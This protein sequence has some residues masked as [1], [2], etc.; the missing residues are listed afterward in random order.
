MEA[1]SLRIATLRMKNFQ[2]FGPKPT[3]IDLTGVTFVLGPNGAGKT[4]VLE[5]LARLFSPIAAQ[6]S[7][8]LTDFH[9]PLNIA[10]ATA[11]AVAE[12]LWIEVEIEFPETGKDGQHPSVPANFAHMRL[13]TE[14]GVPR[15]RVRLTAGTNAFGEVEERIEYV[16]EVDDNEEPIDV[17]TMGRYDR[18]HIEVHYLPARRDPGDHISYATSSLIGRTLRAADWASEAE[19]LTDLS[20]QISNVLGAN[21][22][23]KSLSDGL[24]DQWQGVHTGQFF[25]DPTV[26]FG[27]GEL[28]G[29]LRQLT[30]NFSPS[31]N[32][33]ALSFDRL[34]DGQ[35]SLLYISLVLAWQ[36]LSRR[37]LAGDETG[38]D[39]DKLLPPVH[40]I[41]ALEEPENSLAPQYLGR[42]IRQLRET[43]N[44]GD[45]QALI[46]THAPTMLRRVNPADI[47]FLRLNT[48]R[49][50]T[51]HRI[52]IPK[53]EPDAAKYVQE[54]VMAYP[55]LYFSRLV[56][57]GEGASELVVL[58][59]I[60]AAAGIA[61]DDASVSVVP[62]GGRH[63]NHF[64]K[65][66][67][68]L[69]IPYVTLLDLDCARNGG[70]WGRVRNAL[71]QVNK[72]EFTY[73]EEHINSLPQWNDDGSIPEIGVKPTAL[74]KLAEAHRV[75]FSY[76]VDL[77]LMM[78]ESFPAAYKVSPREPKDSTIK[79]VLG[80]NH[81]NEHLLGV[82]V[83]NLLEDY[84]DKFG[85]KSKPASHL[86]ALSQLGDDNLREGLPE[87]LKSLIEAVK[88]LLS[89]LP[90]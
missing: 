85:R 16:L 43:C 31:H 25:K 71:K 61:E 68:D 1:E 21:I 81:S 59:R 52:K 82:D 60:L 40:T 28:E 20:E 56:V 33:D 12:E 65:L 54:A 23:V 9:A 51:V 8:R 57:L 46:A 90:E 17:Q 87:V 78:M 79:A 7:V 27:H 32:G 69:H 63:V 80:K 48:S 47:C 76:P 74:D 62:L 88:R 34:S 44:V 5:A 77:D 30:I 73:E 49:E 37:V 4:A 84:R 45:A 18:G 2:S 22:A 14:D 39:P 89:E 6:R 50:T 26:A 70:G 83:L 53:D 35:K 42:V 67:D 55:E 36:K 19:Q 64:W 24:I 3:T 86:A 10:E 75:F 29:V 13:E 38:L 15:S 58:P 11:P 66:L 72:L 41:F